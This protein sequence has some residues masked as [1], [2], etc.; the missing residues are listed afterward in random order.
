LRPVDCSVSVLA[1]AVETVLD[2]DRD[3]GVD[4]DDD[5]GGV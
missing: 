2:R 3:G 5:N 1:L 4:D